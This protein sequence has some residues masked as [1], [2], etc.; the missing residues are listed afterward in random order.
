MDNIQLYA[1]N[2]CAID[3]NE[4]ELF[5]PLSGMV[6]Q[7]ISKKISL[8]HH[9]GHTKPA[10]RE[11]IQCYKDRMTQMSHLIVVFGGVSHVVS[12]FFSRYHHWMRNWTGPL[13]EW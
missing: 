8:A 11:S 12:S 6:R 5:S 7:R 1:F 3:T 2:A 13:Q 9:A 10:A 4:L